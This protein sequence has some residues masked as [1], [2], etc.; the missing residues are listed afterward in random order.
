M[1][2]VS[3]LLGIHFDKGGFLQ[4]LFAI[5][6]H[7]P[8]TSIATLAVG[9][10]MIAILLGIEH[11]YPKAPAPLIAVA[12]GIAG[13]SLFG[14]QNYGVSAVGAIPRGLPSFHMP[15]FSLAVK[16]WPGAL[17]IA[18]MSF[19]MNRLP[20]HGLS[21]KVKSLHSGRIESCFRLVSQ[22]QAG[23]FWVPC[24][25]EVVRVRQQ[26]TAFPAHVPNYLS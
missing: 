24:R 10:I 21:Q 15:D 9:V 7:L 8:Q 25:P 20:L 3:K 5:V 12:V 14:L 11:F 16:L 4:N 19:T 17:G 26:S 23:R 13:M 18:L 22:M 2:Q 6:A 1:D